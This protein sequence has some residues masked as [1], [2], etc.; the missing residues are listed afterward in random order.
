MN[1]DNPAF[2]VLPFIH[3]H[4]RLSGES[5]V[6]CNS[7]LPVKPDDVNIIRE[8][9]L[10]GEKI[11]HCRT[12]YSYEGQG[13]I[14]PRMK[15]NERW[16]ADTEVKNYIETYTSEREEITF[17]YDLR[18]SNICNLACIGCMPQDTIATLIER[19]YGRINDIPNSEDCTKYIMERAILTP[20]NEDVDAINKEITVSYTHL[21]L[22]TNREV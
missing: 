6:C 12:C 22:P 5:T 17:S 11:N 21:T 13:I 18:Y 20:L 7:Q 16:L 1:Y 2:C 14:S 9:L 10:T 19:I 8:K 3:K 15:E 4:T